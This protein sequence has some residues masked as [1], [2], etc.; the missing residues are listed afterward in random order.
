[1]SKLV[2]KFEVN[3]ILYFGFADH[4]RATQLFLTRKITR[5]HSQLQSILA[6]QVLH[7]E[8]KT[9]PQLPEEAGFE[10]QVSGCAPMII[11]AH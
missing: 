3:G 9:L 4:R 2:V 10:P 1:M 5:G 7:K 6:L 11:N 8:G